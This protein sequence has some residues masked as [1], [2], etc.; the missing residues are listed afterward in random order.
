VA[1]LTLWQLFHDKVVV[2][3]GAAIGILFLHF[4]QILVKNSCGVGIISLLLLFSDFLRFG[5][6]VLM[7]LPLKLEKAL[8]LFI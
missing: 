6:V 5:S 2:L 3:D 4:R 8:R 1:E 7:P